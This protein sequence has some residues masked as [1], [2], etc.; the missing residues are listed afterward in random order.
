M[1][2]RL[3]AP[4]P[5]SRGWSVLHRESVVFRGS[6]AARRDLMSGSTVLSMSAEPE[7]RVVGQALESLGQSSGP[8]GL[9]EAILRRGEGRQVVLNQAIVGVRR[10]VSNYLSIVVP[11]VSSP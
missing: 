10:G 2:H 8:L 7:S 5:I 4:P 3:L 9:V 1:N 11:A 6:I